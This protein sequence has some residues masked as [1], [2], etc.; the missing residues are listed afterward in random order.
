MQAPNGMRAH[1]LKQQARMHPHLNETRHQQGGVDD[2]LVQAE[3][4]L[5][6]CMMME[7][8]QYSSRSSQKNAV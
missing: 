3:G 7:F 6:A 2:E 5:V 8:N 1:A 4:P